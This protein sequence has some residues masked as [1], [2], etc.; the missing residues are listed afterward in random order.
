MENICVCKRE[1]DLER[2]REGK[3][4][5]EK[6]TQPKNDLFRTPKKANT[7]TNKQTN[8]QTDKQTKRITK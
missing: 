4:M 8:V 7:Q 3:S 2:D 5:I 6:K 1:H